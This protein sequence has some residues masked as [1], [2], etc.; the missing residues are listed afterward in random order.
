[1]PITGF[2]DFFSVPEGFDALLGGGVFLKKALLAG[3]IPSG[4]RQLGFGLLQLGGNLSGNEFNQQIPLG[5]P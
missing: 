1:L 2:G 3:Q 4:L 5:N